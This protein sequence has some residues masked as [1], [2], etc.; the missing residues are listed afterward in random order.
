MSLSLVTLNIERD[1]HLERIK[2][3]LLE[4]QPDV[5]C[6][7]ELVEDDIQFFEELLGAV[8][9]FVPMTRMQTDRGFMTEGVGIFSR[10]GFA[11]TSFM[12]LGGKEGDLTTY[13]DGTSE[14]KNESQRY[15]LAVADIEH[16]GETFRVAT[17]HFPVTV[18]G[19]TNDIQLGVVNSFLSKIAGLGELVVTGDFNAPRGRTAFSLL[20]DHLT[21]NVPLEYDSSID[22]DLHRAGPLPYMV[23]GIFSTSGYRVSEVEMVCG[24]SDHCA[25]AGFVERV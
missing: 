25:L 3:F 20:A 23:D 18:H 15:V 21:D 9:F 4:R 22:A 2:P 13:V 16:E 12:Q 10:T 17:T 1:K 19:E 6:L 24:L 7:Q 5:V 11:S 14:E 8:C